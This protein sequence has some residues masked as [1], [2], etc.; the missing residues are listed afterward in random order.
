[1]D[2]ARVAKLACEIVLSMDITSSD[3]ASGGAWR[4]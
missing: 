3:R 4:L 2:K 1:M